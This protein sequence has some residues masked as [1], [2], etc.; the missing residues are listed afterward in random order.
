MNRALIRFCLLVVFSVGMLQP[1]ALRAQQNGNKTR[2]LFLLDASGSML[3]Q[4]DKGKDRMDVAKRLLGSV[5]DSLAQY[6]NVEVALRVYGHQSPIVDQ[7]CKDTKL[8]VG[9]KANNHGDIKK[10]LQTI[11]PKG[12]TLIAYSLTQAAN[13][14]PDKNARNIIILITDGLEECKGDP[15]AVS[16]ALQRNGVA[17]RPFII[18]VGAMTDDFRKAFECVG[19]FYDASTEA[20]FANALN[21]VVSQALNTTTAQVNLLDIYS[22][23]SETNVNMSFYDSH[24]GLL[25]YNYLHVINDRGYPDT[26]TLDPTVKY[27]VVVHTTPQVVKE[28]VELVPG[29]HN[30]IGIDAPQGYLKLACEGI[31]NYPRLECIIRK[32]GDMQTMYVQEFNST[33]KMLVGKYDLEILTLPRMKLSGVS[34]NQSTTTNISVPQPGKLNILSGTEVWGAVYQMVNNRMELVCEIDLVNKT[35]TI[36][37]QPGIYKIVYRP[38]NMTRSYY[39][40]ERE[41]KITSAYATTINL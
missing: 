40:F 19:R 31:T 37:M 13:D 23:P 39:T 24:T 3:A 20:T 4:M 12:T 33:H 21:V 32:G 18:G 8:E 36:T 11:S 14:F 22:K 9:F 7:N 35:Q 29:K 28:G 10:K 5:L 41:F 27:T 15:C 38:K 34:I 30:I 6:K 17:L 2:I 25:L 1:A 16:E 26:I